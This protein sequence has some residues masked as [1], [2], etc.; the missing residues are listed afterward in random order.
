[1]ATSLVGQPGVYTFSANSGTNHTISVASST[2]SGGVT[3]Y[4]QTPNGQP[5]TQGTVSGT[6]GTVTLSNLPTTGTYT[7]QIVP[8]GNSTGSLKVSVS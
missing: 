2:Y 4:V 1:M 6:S 7:I 8:S 5:Y 3:L